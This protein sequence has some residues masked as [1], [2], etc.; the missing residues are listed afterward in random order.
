MARAKTGGRKAGTR[1][2]ATAA[3]IAKAAQGLIP[4]DYL[5]SILRDEAQPIEVRMRAAHDAAPYCH[6][7]LSATM[8]S[9]DPDNPPL[10][11]IRITLVSHRRGTR[12]RMCAQR[13]GGHS[14]IS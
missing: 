4:L 11:E 2:K 1:N 14:G 7:R 10:R 9:A 6:Q 12:G 8:L 3:N 13:A 5:L